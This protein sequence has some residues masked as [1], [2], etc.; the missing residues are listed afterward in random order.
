MK[1]STNESGYHIVIWL[2]L[3][4]DWLSHFKTHKIV[5]NVKKSD[6]NF[7]RN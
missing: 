3:K 6:H 7:F 5:K 2:L 4:R 1:I